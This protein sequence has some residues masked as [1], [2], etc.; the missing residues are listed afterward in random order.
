MWRLQKVTAPGQELV[1]H[2]KAQIMVFILW[3]LNR[4][5]TQDVICLLASFNGAGN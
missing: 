5:N 2:I 1:Q 3:Y 4:L